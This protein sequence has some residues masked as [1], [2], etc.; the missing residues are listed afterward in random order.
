[1]HVVCIM[2]ACPAVSN[3]SACMRR[4]AQLTRVVLWLLPCLWCF[5]ATDKRQQL[6]G[7]ATGFTQPLHRRPALF[8]HSATIGKWW[9]CA[10]ACKGSKA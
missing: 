9:F 1:M 5:C 8:S 10:L 2:K 3:L 7:G 6:V 4:G